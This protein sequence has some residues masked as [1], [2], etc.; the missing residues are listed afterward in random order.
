MVYQLYITNKNYSSWS[1]RAWV[2]LTKLGI[3]FEEKLVVAKDGSISQPEWASFSP[4]AKVPCLHDTGPAEALVIWDSLAIAEYVAEAYPDKAVWPPAKTAARAWARSATCE[5]HAGFVAAR[6]E[7]SMSCGVRVELGEPSPEL[8][9]DLDRFAEL[10]TEGLSRF[11]GPFLAGD[12]FGAVDAFF[13]PI[14]VRLQTFGALGLVGEKGRQY[15]EMLLALPEVKRWVD[16][17]TA[18]V[19]RERVHDEDTLRGRRLLADYRATK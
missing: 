11:G 5:M 12:T 17:G 16:D 1:M 14:A 6:S 8:R 7:M 10:W 15:A 19:W 18:E 3:P 9:K 2:L 4:T 13:V